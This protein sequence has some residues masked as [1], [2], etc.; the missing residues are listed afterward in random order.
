VPPA[1]P[2]AARGGG[3]IEARSVVDLWVRGIVNMTDESDNGMFHD[4]VFRR[5]ILEN[6]K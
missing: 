2:G 4:R 3:E 1:D 5:Y 6:I